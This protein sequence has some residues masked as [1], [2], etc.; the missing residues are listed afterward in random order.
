M[1]KPRGTLWEIWQS[2]QSWFPPVWFKS[3]VA[4]CLQFVHFCFPAAHSAVPSQST[5]L[6]SHPPCSPISIHPSALTFS[7]AP[8]PAHPPCCPQPI[9]PSVLISS[10]QLLPLHPPHWSQITHP[11]PLPP[12]NC[13]IQLLLNRLCVEREKWDR[14]WN[15]ESP[16]L[17]VPQPCR[18]SKPKLDTKTVHTW[19]YGGHKGQYMAGTEE[20]TWWAQRTVHGG[21]KGWYMVDSKESTWQ[22]QRTVHGGHKW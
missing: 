18:W 11:T 3:S 12:I 4:S 8:L 19:L 21:P 17:L 9:H 6:P 16:V 20:S 22:A 5:L 13:Q 2:N 10:N 1:C 15:S 7:T 14:D